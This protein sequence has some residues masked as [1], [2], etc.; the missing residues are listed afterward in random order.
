MALAA[1]DVTTTARDVT[2]TARDI[3]LGYRDTALDY[4][5]DAQAA[6][7]SLDTSLLLSKAG[8]LSGLASLPTSRT[9]LGLGSAATVNVTRSTSSPSGGVDGDIWFQV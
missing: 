5:N 8:N 4:R 9:N 1:R 2:T 6:A 3:T 7:A